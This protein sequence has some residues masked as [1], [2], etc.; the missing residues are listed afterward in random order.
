MKNEKQM[1]E[2]IRGGEG[3]GEN[4]NKTKQQNQ[5][6]PNNI[7]PEVGWIGYWRCQEREQNII[8]MYYVKKFKE[9]IQLHKRYRCGVAIE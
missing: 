1:R 4:K 5:K 2:G 6:T 9:A 7:K 8:K 3:N